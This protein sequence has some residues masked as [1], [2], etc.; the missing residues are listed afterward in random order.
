MSGALVAPDLQRSFSLSAD[1]LEIL[2][3]ARPQRSS[4]DGDIATPNDILED[5]AAIA[6][7]SDPASPEDDP[8]I[9]DS[10]TE[11]ALDAVFEELGSRQR[12]LGP[13]YPFDLNISKRGLT[14]SVSSAHEDPLTERARAIYI[15]CLYMTGIRGGLID[16]KAAKIKADPDMGN[17]FQ[18]CATIAAAGYMSG[19]AYWFGHPRPDKTPFMDA[20]RNVAGWL[21]GTPA[22]KAPAGETL[23]AKDGGIDV[24]AWRDHH[25]GR[26]AKLIM[27]GQCASGMDWVGKP[28]SGKVNRMEAYYTYAPSKHWIP[29]LF[30]PFPLYSE[31]ENAHNLRSREAMEGF[32]RTFEAEMGVI[33]DRFRIVMWSLAALRDVQPSVKIAVD[34]LDELFAWSQSAADAAKLA[35]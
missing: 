32:Y 19:D 35:A 21:Q 1:W 29:A 11:Q 15:A 2:A 27:Y 12:I 14:L 7:D 3:L 22:P 23:Y 6:A 10:A 30:T 33:I 28:V 17:A 9:L 13:A 16:A 26:P 8:D 31:K 20:I 5:R 4:T 34:K 24:I 25:D 18:I